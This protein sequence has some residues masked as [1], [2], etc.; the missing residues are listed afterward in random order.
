MVIVKFIIAP[1]LTCILLCIDWYVWKAVKAALKNRGTRTRESVTY[2]FWGV[3]F[4][5]LRFLWGYIFIDEDLLS[6]DARLVMLMVVI[7]VYP[8]KLFS[9]A[10]ITCTDLLNPPKGI[11][12]KAVRKK[13]L[14]MP[15][16]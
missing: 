4:V 5:A 14:P 2:L 16:N 8:A 9:L 15:K 6:A 11:K 7:A 1:L 3:T 10:L 13:A 12:E